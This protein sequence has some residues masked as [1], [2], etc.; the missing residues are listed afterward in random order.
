MNKK[1]IV[2]YGGNSKE[3]EVSIATKDSIIKALD[4]LAYKYEAW[5]LSDA[6]FSKLKGKKD[7]I[8]LNATHGTFG[9]D[10][11]VQ[12]ALDILNIPYTH[13]AFRASQIA[14]DKLLSKNLADFLNINTAKYSFLHGV[15]DICEQAKKL[16]K[17]PLC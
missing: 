11:R 17:N 7:I 8:V 14:M 6:I 2:I 3:R 10:G 16:C 4:E 1:I 15:D 9:E 12:A 13:S 5:E